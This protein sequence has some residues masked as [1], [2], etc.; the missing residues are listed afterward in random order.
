VVA[1]GC[2]E[3]YVPEII[4]SN[5]DY[6]VVDAFLTDNGTATVNITHSLPLDS[7]ARPEPEEHA[8]VSLHN[9]VG[10]V[11][12]LSYAGEGLYTATGLHININDRYQLKIKTADARQYESD[13][14]PVKISPPI[15]SV[16]WE[17]EGEEL[18]IN[19]STHDD[20]KS[21]TYYR[22][23]AVETFEYHAIYSSPFYLLDSIIYLK[24]PEER[25][26]FCWRTQPVLEIFVYST[27]GFTKD[28]VDKYRLQTIPSNDL[29]IS[30]KYSIHVSQQTLTQEA[31]NYW[32]NVRKTTEDLGG[33]FDPMPGAV[34]GN[35]RCTSHPDEPVIGFFSAGS[36]TEQRIFISA[37]ELRNFM[38]YRPPY[39][40]VDTIGAIEFGYYNIYTLIAPTYYQDQGTPPILNGYSY[41]TEYCTDC[42]RYA[43]GTTQRPEYWPQ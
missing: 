11:A 10:P 8:T 13:F 33:L 22:W 29:R 4:T 34:N 1:I 3:P 28:H 30:T 26:D 7:V 32:L 18:F 31:Y 20:T 17:I 37:L 14:I 9:E 40:E 23:R 15:D 16:T 35:I 21:S 5:Q 43:G 36:V 2:L 12:N 38:K 27:E 25:H 41:S 42:I 39:C 6:L 24:T 19:V